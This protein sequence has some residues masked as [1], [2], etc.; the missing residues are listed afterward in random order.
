[1]VMGVYKVLYSSYITPNFLQ[2]KE[3]ITFEELKAFL[4]EVSVGPQPWNFVLQFSK[5]LPSVSAGA[6]AWSL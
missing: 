3:E 5:N 2:R 6:R 4:K 1:M